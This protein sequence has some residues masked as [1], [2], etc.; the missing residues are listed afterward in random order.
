MAKIHLRQATVLG[1]ILKIKK[2]QIFK[3]TGDIYRNERDKSCFQPVMA[4]GYFK[5][6]PRKT[7]SDK[8]L[9]D[10]AFKIAK[11]PKYYE[12]LRDLASIV[13]KFCD[14]KSARRVQNSLLLLTQK[15]VLIL[16]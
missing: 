5:Y 4:D 3:K 1:N 15:Q 6:L 14:I 10:K 12:Y 2:V 8:V 7:A 11:N 16:V 13:Y 9:R